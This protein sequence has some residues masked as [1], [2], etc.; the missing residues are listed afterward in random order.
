MR[1]RSLIVV[2]LFMTVLPVLSPSNPRNA[3]P[4]NF[5]VLAGHTGMGTYCEDGTPGCLPGDLPSVRISRPVGS[6][7]GKESPSTV[8]RFGLGVVP[9]MFVL[10]RWIVS[11]L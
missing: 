4:T 9:V 6:A 5:S 10:L 11:L 2:A 7:P 3:S 8:S 1:A